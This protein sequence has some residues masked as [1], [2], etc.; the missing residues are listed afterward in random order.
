MTNG[1]DERSSRTWWAV[2]RP[3]RTPDMTEDVSCRTAK[4]PVAIVKAS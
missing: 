1:S 2:D 3:D 4:S